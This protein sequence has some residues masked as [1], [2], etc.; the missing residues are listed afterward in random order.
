MSLA[1]WQG[2]VGYFRRIPTLKKLFWLYFLLLIFEGALRKWIFPEYSAPLLVVRD[3]VAVLIILEAYREN[4]W[5]ERWSVITGI[6][7]V[8][9]IGLCA[10]QVI[11]GDNPWVAA[12]YGLRSYLL[13]FPVAFIMGECLDEEDLRMFGL[14]TLLLAL[15]ETAL[16]IA[17]YLAPP[18]SILNVGAYAGGGQ[19]G[20]IGGHVRASGTFS[21]VVGPASFGP[22]AAAFILH[23]LAR[24]KFAKTWLLWASAL[25]VLVSVPVDGS[26]TF[27]VQLAAVVACAGIAAAFGVSQLLKSLKILVPLFL[28]FVLASYLPVFSESSK[29]LGQRMQQANAVEGK[30]SFG[31]AVEQRTVAPVLL[32]LADTDF[33]S[34][35]IGI[36]MGRG[37]AAVTK[38]LQGRT[39]FTVGENEIDRAIRELG[40]LPG[41]A[42]TLFRLGLAL[43]VLGKAIQ[44]ARKGEPLALL[45]SPL[46]FYAVVISILEQPT[47]QGFMVVLLAFSLAALNPSRIAVRQARASRRFEQP[48]RYSH[49]AR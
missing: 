44:R 35:P 18:G 20:Y 4:K 15:P 31:Q 11:A 2:M 47:D 3:P 24:E 17:Q 32:R 41:L 14:C 23:G 33:G 7:T 8:G 40:P 25:A 26:R 21:F 13:P 1:E 19:I 5:P 38:L 43:T 48:L 16:E 22:M 29:S 46:V 30:G 49:P 9:L 34:N 27:V 10:I 12:V 39:E 37:A 6:L 28:V 45:L 42:F 36:G